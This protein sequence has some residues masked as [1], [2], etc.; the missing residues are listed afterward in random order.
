MQRLSKSILL[1]LMI[2][3]FKW[4]WIGLR[5]TIVLKCLSVYC[6]ALILLLH[7]YSIIN[8]N[9]WN[10]RMEGWYI[11]FRDSGDF[12]SFGP[13]LSKWEMLTLS[14]NISLRPYGS[15]NTT[16]IWNYNGGSLGHCKKHGLAALLGWFYSWHGAVRKNTF[17]LG[18]LAR[19]CS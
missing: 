5:Y 9:S 12:R 16:L 19:L 18:S 4:F 6:F 7:C 13:A 2:N 17:A 10:E 11:C 15:R 14:F 3:N 8:E 1:Q